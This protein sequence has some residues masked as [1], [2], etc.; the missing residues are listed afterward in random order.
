MPKPR[1]FTLIELLVVISILAILA[2]VGAAVFANVQKRTNDA[3][4]RADLRAIYVALEQHFVKYGSYT[5]PE[6]FCSDT[7][8]G[9]LGSCGSPWNPGDWESNSNLRILVTDKML[10]SL[11]K[12]PINNATYYYY[13]EPTNFNEPA[14]SNNPAGTYYIL[15]ATRLETTGSAYCLD[16][17][18]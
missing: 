18:P 17:W 14:G 9:S 4:R 13:Y 6:V 11:P 12:D 5:Q 16:T 3:K 7:S 1:G 8:N 2:V 10:M 15:C